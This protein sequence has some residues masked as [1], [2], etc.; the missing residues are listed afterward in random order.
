MDRNGV[1]AAIFGRM[2]KARAGFAA[3]VPLSGGKAIRFQGE[4]GR[5]LTVRVVAMNG[6]VLEEK[7]LKLNAAGASAALELNGL[8]QGLYG[9]IWEDKGL[10]GSAKFLRR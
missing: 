4:A 10:Q 9:V 5:T 1:P 6:K 7:S 2:P 3:L 8:R